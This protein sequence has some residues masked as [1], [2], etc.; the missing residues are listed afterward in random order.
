MKILLTILT[1]IFSLNS[2]STETLTYYVYFETEYIQGPWSRLDIVEQSNYKYLK[3]EAYDDLFGSENEQLV[4]KMLSRLKEKKP[5]FYSWE[6][7]LSFRGDTVVIA[8]NELPKNIKTIKNEIIATLTFN[9][10]K[11]L[12]FNFAN[13]S[14]TLTIR[15]LTI[16]YFDLVSTEFITSK[17]IDKKDNL[18]DQNQIIAPIETK[19]SY[20]TCLI[21]SIVLNIGLIGILTLRLFK[22]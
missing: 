12:I 13:K 17:S 1:F 14:E 18:I 19:Y 5:D 3:A 11:V 22:K 15:D 8:T 20:K 21:I 10:F 2:F 7:D 9:N 4:Q 16:P 6:Y